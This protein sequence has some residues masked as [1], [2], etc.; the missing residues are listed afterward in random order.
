MKRIKSTANYNSTAWSVFYLSLSFFLHF[1]H[2]IVQV[3]FSFQFDQLFTFHLTNILSQSISL[4]GV[5][6]L[7]VKVFDK[8]MASHSGNANHNN[9]PP[10]KKPKTG[11]QKPPGRSKGIIW[12]SFTEEMTDTGKKQR[13]NQCNL[14]VSSQ[15][16]RLKLHE[17][18]CLKRDQPVTLGTDEQ[19][20]GGSP[21]APPRQNP[22]PQPSNS[23]SR[24]P[25]IS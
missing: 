18:N 25:K 19:Q 21:G 13:C 6:S 8:Q 24:Q 12:S 9:V 16:Q 22:N 3:Q 1:T 4:P 11:H 7:S 5:V 15:S 10:T 17:Q 20:Q 14:L 2:L 23:G